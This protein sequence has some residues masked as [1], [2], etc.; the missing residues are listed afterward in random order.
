MS[1][2]PP[3][4][5]VQL[6]YTQFHQ[7]AKACSFCPSCGHRRQVSTPVPALQVLGDA[8]GYSVGLALLVHDTQGCCVPGGV[9]HSQLVPIFLSNLF[10][11][12]A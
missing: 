6:K 11:G 5:V 4:Q 8:W 12:L 7:D 3:R 9:L 10:Y 1:G 2:V